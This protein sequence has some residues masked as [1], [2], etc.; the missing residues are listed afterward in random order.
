M[1][2]GMASLFALRVP[3]PANLVLRSLRMRIQPLDRR[4]VVVQKM[5]PLRMHRSLPWRTLDP[6]YPQRILERGIL[7][8]KRI[9]PGLHLLS[10]RRVEALLLRLISLVRHRPR[11]RT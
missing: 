2:R 11:L 6:Q 4:K 10:L 9:L 3:M 5:L 1:R 7:L 8:Y